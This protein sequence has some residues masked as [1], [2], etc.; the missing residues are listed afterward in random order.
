MSRRWPYVVV[1]AVL[2]A[3]VAVWVVPDVDR[4][5]FAIAFGGTGEG[6]PPLPSLSPDPF[7]LADS[8]QI[9]LLAVGIGLLV[10]IYSTA[11]LGHHPRYRSYALIIVLFLVAMLAVVGTSNLWVLLVGW[12]VM[13][14][15]SYLLIGHEWETGEARAGAAKAFLVTR[16]ADLGLVVAII[17]I[18]ETYGTYDVI[19]AWV[20]AGDQP[21]HET[22]IGLLVL[23]AVMGK[24]AQFPLHTWLPDAMPGP[25][26]ITALIHAATM[27]AAGVYL[28]A[29]LFPLYRGSEVALTA[30]AVVAGVTM[31]L[32]A[33]FA[34]VQAD[35]KRALAWSTVSQLALMF[36]AIAGGEPEAGTDHLVA[37]GVFKALLFLGC[38]CLMH[39]VGSSA[40]SAMGGLRVSMPT[41]FWTMTAGFAALAGLVPT[42]GFFTKDSVLEALL[43]ATDGD[44]GLPTPVAY[45]LLGAALVTTLLTAAYATR[46]WLEAFFGPV[47]DGHRGHEAPR[48]MVGP[49]VVLTVAT[50]ALSIGQPLHLGVGLLSTVVAVAGVGIVLWKWRGGSALDGSPAPLRAEL[51]IDRVYDRWIPALARGASRAVVDVDRD[52]VDA[53]PRGSAALADLASTALGLVQSRNAQRYA[54]VIAVGVVVLVLLGVV[55]S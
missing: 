28:A 17:V 3:V 40:L 44:H 27:V 11:Y 55:W 34:L 23:V 18:G 20:R 48:A 14:L 25:T 30:M 32:G 24:S 1:T 49:L 9:A 2:A 33:A 31:L 41:T 37:H 8:A 29:H 39:A 22:L 51:G 10:Q 54:T 47:P 4:T 42:V 43:E 26:P 13:G 21:R 53:Y 16:V 46:L 5:S 15:C 35:L 19:E 7:W 38:G 50:F 36:A 12:E 6:P 52:A 45:L